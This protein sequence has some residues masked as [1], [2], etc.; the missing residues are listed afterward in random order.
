MYPSLVHEASNNLK[1]KTLRV[2]VL[3]LQLSDGSQS[4]HGSVDPGLTDKR[5]PG[6]L[7]LT[8]VPL[9][10]ALYPQHSLKSLVFSFL[11]CQIRV[12]V[13]FGVLN[14]KFR[15]LWWYVE[16]RRQSNYKLLKH[17]N[18]TRFDP[19]FQYRCSFVL[20]VIARFYAS[21]LFTVFSVFW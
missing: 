17:T 8:V 4:C 5:S 3:T 10:K 9:G 2:S 13:F 7:A 20:L 19:D 14:F 18:W 12:L 1:F 6:P 15:D 16:N 21:F 11:I